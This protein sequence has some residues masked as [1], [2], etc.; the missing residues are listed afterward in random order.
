M[1]RALIVLLVPLLAAL[2]ASGTAVATGSGDDPAPR[3]A[4]G[5]SVAAERGPGQPPLCTHGPDPL[6]K[7]D[8]VFGGTAAGSTLGSGALGSTGTVGAAAGAHCVDPA[9]TSDAVQFVYGFPAQTSARPDGQ[10]P[11]I[12]QTVASFDG[13]LD[14]HAG[15][16]VNVVCDTAGRLAIPSVQLPAI[17]ADEAFTYNDMVTGLKAAGLASTARDYVVFTD[18][19]GASYPYCGQ[20]NK[21]ADDQ[22]DPTRNASNLGPNYSLV[23]CLGTAWLHEL[24]H[25]M[26]G[27]QNSA[28]HA[29][30]GSHCYDQMDIECYNDGGSYFAGGGTLTYPCGTRYVTRVFDCGND[31]YFHRLPAPAGSYLATRWNLASSY[32]LTDQ[33]RLGPDQRAP[34][35]YF[36]N[37]TA[38][39]RVT[40]IEPISLGAIDDT[41]VERIEVYLGDVATGTLLGT[42]SDYPMTLPWDLVPS[43]TSPQ[44]LTAVVTDLGGTATTI[45]LSGLIL[46]RAAPPVTPTLTSATA[47]KSGKTTTVSLAWSDSD[48]D[49]SGF[50]IQRSAS[51]AF[52]TATTLT[53]AASLRTTTDASAAARTTYY[54]RVRAVLASGS[55]TAWSATSTVRT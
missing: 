5:L 21:A 20:G 43:S 19:L 11:V 30:G 22:P 26:G 45:A 55:P 48:S 31:D 32:F 24:V 29:S 23:N 54:Y 12:E 36:G 3:C 49:L 16:R 51:S 13:W 1:R 27:V 35:A 15:Y 9:A 17:G 14:V 34:L 46:N 37:P 6:R 41:S 7:G 53:R 28:P 2:T 47:A 18:N 39:G 38:P 42:I 33:G 8:L 4:P 52:A 40:D 50:E 25:N 10:R 44:T